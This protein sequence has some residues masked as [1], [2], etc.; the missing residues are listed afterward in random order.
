MGYAF[1]LL[2]KLKLFQKE[3]KE[4]QY[5]YSPTTNLDIISNLNSHSLTFNQILNISTIKF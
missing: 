4:T 3:T 5:Y 1:I 2:V